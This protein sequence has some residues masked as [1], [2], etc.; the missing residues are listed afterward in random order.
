MK[1]DKIYP[2]IQNLPYIKKHNAKVLYK[3]IIENEIKEVLELGFAHGKATLVVASALQEVGGGCVTSVDLKAS[4]FEPS[5][6]NLLQKSELKN[7]SRYVEIRRMKSGYSWFLRNEIRENTQKGKCKEKYGLCIIDGPKN[8]TIDGHA[9]FCVDKLLKN[10]GWFIFDDYDWR[11]ANQSGKTTDGI[12]HRSMSEEEIN[13]AHIKEVFELLVMQHSS[14]GQF[15]IHEQG[16]WAWAKKEIGKKKN[17]KRVNHVVASPIQYRLVK[18]GR[19]V[20]SALK[21]RVS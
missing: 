21:N 1:F 18:F 6:E 17:K 10:G 19:R 12:S 3:F 11:Y 2:K 9:F 5:L 20:L 14:Y 4:S 13:T 8:W 15:K 16:D 7:L